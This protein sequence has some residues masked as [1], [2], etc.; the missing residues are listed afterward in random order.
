MVGLL[1]VSMYFFRFCNST[2]NI[3]ANS[4]RTARANEFDMS[5]PVGTVTGYGMYDRGIVIRFPGG[6][7]DLSLPHIIQ[8]DSV[9]QLSS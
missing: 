6:V 9:V 2:P 7:T 4:V 8:I 3:L 1:Y 5:D